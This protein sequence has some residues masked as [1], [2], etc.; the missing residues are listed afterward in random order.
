MKKKVGASEREKC[1]ETRA[2]VMTRVWVVRGGENTAI[3][4]SS[5]LL[6]RKHCHRRCCWLGF[7]VQQQQRTSMFSNE[8]IPVI[9]FPTNIPRR[10]NAISGL[11]YNCEIT[12]SF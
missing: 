2:G 3:S 11:F 4:L 1:N 12:P 9:N 10:P 5:K 8:F 6:L 7:A